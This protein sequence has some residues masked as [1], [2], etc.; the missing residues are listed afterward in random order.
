M[1]SKMSW[2]L[3]IVF[4]IALVSGCLYGLDRYMDDGIN[5][6]QGSREHADEV[7]AIRPIISGEEK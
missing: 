2:V 4:C 5:I 3:W 6:V 7:H 1:K